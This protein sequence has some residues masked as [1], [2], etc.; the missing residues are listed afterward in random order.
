MRA[1]AAI[2][3]TTLQLHAYA[4][5]AAPVVSPDWA[6]ES[7]LPGAREQAIKEAVRE[8]AAEASAAKPVQGS[9]TFRSDRVER[10]ERGFEE[11]RVPG[12]LRPDGLKNQPTGIGPFQLGGL[13][14]LP[15]VAVAKMRGKC[16]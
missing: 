1:C 5:S 15:F 14:A 13:L 4:Q 8:I 2:V 10:F 3:L 9:G 12:C 16:R 7:A 11:A 6:A